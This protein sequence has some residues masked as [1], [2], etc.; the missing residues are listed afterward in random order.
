MPR[1]DPARTAHARAPR[2]SS[3]TWSVR[4]PLVAWLQ[5][6]AERAAADLGSYRVLEDA[7]IMPAPKNVKHPGLDLR[8]VFV[9]SSAGADAA[10]KARANKLA[11]ARDDLV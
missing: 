7:W 2:R 1:P 8:R 5:A 4:A 10:S 11:R 3:I 6:E 9:W